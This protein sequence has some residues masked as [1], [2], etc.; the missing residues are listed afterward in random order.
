M[1]ARAL[2]SGAGPSNRPL[3]PGR[4]AAVFGSSERARANRAAS[5]RAVGTNA[6][7]N[8]LHLANIMHNEALVSVVRTLAPNAMARLNMAMR[9]TLTKSEAWAGLWACKSPAQ[10]VRLARNDR[11]Y[12]KATGHPI[13]E[14]HGLG[15]EWKS[16]SYT[17]NA[18]NLGK[19]DLLAWARAMGCQW[20]V[21]VR[22][23]VAFMKVPYGVQDTGEGA[24]EKCLHL[25]EI[26]F[27]LSMHTIGENAC[28]S[29]S[30]LKTVLMDVADGH[31]GITWPTLDIGA[32]AFEDCTFLEKVVFSPRLTTIQESAFLSCASLKKIDV[33]A[34]KLA[35]IGTRAFGDTGLTGSVV[36]PPTLA[37]IETGAFAGCEQLRT[38]VFKDNIPK[39]VFNSDEEDYVVEYVFDRHVMIQLRRLSLH[40]RTLLQNPTHV[41]VW[42]KE[43]EGAFRVMRRL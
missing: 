32:G 2:G 29:C 34:T 4:G 10:A 3:S 35:W 23:A 20:S 11:R 16:A 17:T 41:V 24:F 1:P 33:A 43:T 36:F 40:K 14:A 5:T 19:N 15:W 21:T 39:I 28:K 22:N 25:Q 31:S 38:V 8:R 9:R 13:L 42:L 12:V 27:P 6:R 18:Y 30:F 37:R 7:A 26:H